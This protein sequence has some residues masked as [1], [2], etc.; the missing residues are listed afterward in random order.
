[1]LS[2]V[3]GRRRHEIGIRIALGAQRRQVS[4]LVVRQGLALVAIGLALGVPLSLAGSRALGSLLFG[5]SAYDLTTYAGVVAVLV[6]TGGLAAYIPA[7]RA[8]RV[9]PKIA[10]SDGA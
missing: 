2:Y 3:V 10:L 1:M 8:A 9:E 5:L 6:I 7:R 4:F